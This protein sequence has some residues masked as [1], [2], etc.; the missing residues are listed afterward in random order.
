M[1]P[2]I[3]EQLQAT[4]VAQVIVVLKRA[5]RPAAAA[6]EA[7]PATAGVAAAAA[8]LR[9]YFLTGP[10][11]RQG[12]V[13]LHAPP[14]GLPATASALES[15]PAP[16]GGPLVFEHLGVLLGSADAD[17][18]RAL[19]DHGLV[20]EVTAAPEF[21]L[22]RPVRRT[23]AARPAGSTWGLS[24]LGV[25]GLRAQGLTGEGVLVGHL[26][27]G[28]DAS[29]P[30]FDEGRAIAR[31]AQFDWMGRP[32][33]GAKPHDSGTHGTH[34]AGTIAARAVGKTQFGVA[35]GAGLASGLVIEGGN[36]IARILGG[37]NWLVGL[38]EPRVRVLSLSLGLRGYRED[39]R[40]VIRILRARDILPVIAAGNEG[41]GTSRSPGN[42]PEVLSVGAG[43]A[44]DTVADFSSSQKL[45]R[46]TRVVPGL[47]GPGV[48]V[49]SCVPA[50][51][52][53]EMDG[54]SMATPHVA[55]LAALL[56]Q[57]VP[58]ATAD[59]VER[60]L[61]GSCARPAAMP[62][63]RAGRGVP[64]GPAALALLREGE[65]AA[66]AGGAAGMMGDGATRPARKGKKPR[67]K[68]RASGKGRPQGAR[69]K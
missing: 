8:R 9:S 51:K 58:G 17:G 44:G 23:A 68:A 3:R 36:V 54:T 4:G 63:A 7:A 42:Y 40:P 13:A 67:A 2:A 55:G 57:A 38:R 22:I 59:A 14:T 62:P 48:G 27:T 29:H 47:V 66:P 33:A 56:F 61:L 1:T 39:F 46:P 53:E 20:D 31:F 43:A 16:V 34:T 60:A 41:P 64:D 21:S 49:L 12:A 10:D 45:L 35:P 15:A 25:P 6:L 28:V 52:Y 19:E 11:T 5:E 24:R 65:A 30:A 37:L 18:V 26:D 32:V 50:N 69:K